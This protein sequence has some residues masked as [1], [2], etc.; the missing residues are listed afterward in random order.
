M[1]LNLQNS[2]NKPWEFPMFKGCLG[3]YYRGVELAKGAW[4][5]GG[6][7][8]GIHVFVLIF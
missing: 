7:G 5:G 1:L 4:G 8:G 6:G 3:A 2:E